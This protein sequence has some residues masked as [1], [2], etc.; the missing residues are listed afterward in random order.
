MLLL[1]GILLPDGVLER[2]PMKSSLT[3]SAEVQP[4]KYAAG[5][6]GT[7]CAASGRESNCRFR[8][9]AVAF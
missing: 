8:R 6:D 1:T 5:S 2:W 7:D 4:S 3:N 9:A